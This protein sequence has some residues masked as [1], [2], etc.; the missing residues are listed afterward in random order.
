[1]NCYFCA[2]HRPGGTNFGN[3]SAIGICQN[4]SV[5]VCPEHGQKAV[6]PDAPLLCIECTKLTP[7]TKRV[8]QEPGTEQSNKSTNY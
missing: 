6:T 5:G 1:M 8:K 7:V 4:C 2:Q 3:S